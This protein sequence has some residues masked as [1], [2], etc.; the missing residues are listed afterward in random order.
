[1]NDPLFNTL[2][3]MR[4]PELKNRLLLAP[5]TNQQSEVDGTAS[6]ADFDWIER[7][8]RGG[9]SMIMACAANVQEN[10]KTFKNQLGI[11]ND[12]QLPGLR[13]MADIIRKQGAVSSIQLH[14]GGFRAGF[15]LKGGKSVGPSDNLT[16]NARSL[17]RAEVHQLRDDF[18]GAACRAQKAGFD[19]AEIHA[20]FGWILSQ[21]LSYTLNQRTD[22]YGGS[23]E[24]RARL[25]FEIIEGI[26]KECGQDFQIGLRLSFE[27]Y[28]MDFED[29]LYVA[30]KCLTEELIDYLD[31][32][33]WDVRF[34]L[35]SGV[36]A[37][38]RAIDVFAG[39][40]RSRVKLGASGKLMNANDARRVLEAGLDFVMIGRAA[41]LETDFPEKIKNDPHHT[42]PSL[43]V[44]EA[45]LRENGLSNDFINYMRYW[46]NFVSD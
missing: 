42:S 41:I 35:E 10:G 45:Y 27:R 18:I 1:M 44:T 29:I 24:N 38:K 39:L 15:N 6:E 16:Y 26:R 21:F 34:K 13:R 2:S 22:K 46:D 23:R 25:I 32:A 4:G 9:Y 7:V 17:T 11:W 8:A 33:P 30:R 14:H 28:G 40:P 37:G 36:Y 19:G 12:D 5:L 20:A 31:L 43:P 3:L